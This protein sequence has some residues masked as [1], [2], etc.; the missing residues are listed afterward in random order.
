MPCYAYICKDCGRRWEEW[1]RVDERRDAKC[2]CGG[3][4][5]IDFSTYSSANVMMFTPALYTDLDVYPIWIDSKKKLK[6]ECK[7]RGLRAARL[8]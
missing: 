1:R 6:E 2:Q 8:L 3:K 7:K 5:E 4:A